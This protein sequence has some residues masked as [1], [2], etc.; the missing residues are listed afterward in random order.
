MKLETN[1]AVILEQESTA[2]ETLFR[3]ISGKE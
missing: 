3:K 1:S 2:Q